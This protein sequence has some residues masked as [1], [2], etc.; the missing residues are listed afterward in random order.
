M[1]LQVAHSK[2]PYELDRLVFVSH[3]DFFHI[4][5]S[6]QMKWRC[7]WSNQT[8]QVYTG[9]EFCAKAASRLPVC[10]RG[11]DSS[12]GFVLLLQSVQQLMM[13]VILISGQII[14][15]EQFPASFKCENM[16]R[17]KHIP[18]CAQHLIEFAQRGPVKGRRGD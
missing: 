12:R 11:R 2:I 13:T 18:G 9:I 15:I 6:R 17:V 5:R 16:Y 7:S 14:N 3:F 4:F 1:N 8:V 10:I